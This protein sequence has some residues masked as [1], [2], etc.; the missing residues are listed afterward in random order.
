MSPSPFHWLAFLLGFAI[1][2]W[3]AI[4]LLFILPAEEPPP[5]AATCITCGGAQPGG[6]PPR[7]E[8]P[9][10]IPPGGDS[11][12]CTNTD[13]G[14]GYVEDAGGG[15]VEDGGGGYVEDG[16]GG[17]VE[18][19]APR[20]PAPSDDHGNLQ[21]PRGE[22][23]YHCETNDGGGGYVEDSASRSVAQPMLPES[24]YK[25]WKDPVGNAV[26]LRAETVE[27]D[28]TYTRV[29]LNRNQNVVLYDPV[30]PDTGNLVDLPGDVSSIGRYAYCMV[31]T[32]DDEPIIIDREGNC[33]A[34]SC[35]Q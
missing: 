14:G 8:G 32:A 1:A 2:L 34:G 18:D 19:N 5:A 4:V 10:W 9:H 27:S 21:Q 17:Y 30:T 11:Y 35:P 29:R 3:I 6:R 12:F 20:T 31:A 25:C 28:T 7:P 23:D 16:G 33:L 26:V 24:R 15:Y 22:R 13:G